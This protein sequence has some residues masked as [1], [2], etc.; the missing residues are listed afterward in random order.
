MTTDY[1][2]LLARHDYAIIDRAALA[3]ESEMDG[4]P[5]EPLVPKI[6]QGDADKMPGLVPLEPGA[7]H[8]EMLVYHLECVEQGL[9][10]CLLSCLLAAPDTTPERLGAH[11]T[12]RLI[13][14]S[15]R[16][17]IDL[18][19]YYDP[20]VFQNLERILTPKQLRALYGPVTE[21]TFRFQ[22]EWI[23][24][25]APEVTGVMPQLWAVRANQHEQLNR[26]ILLN[27]V[28]ARRKNSLDRPW[29]DLG[30]YQSAAQTADEA[31]EA[32]QNRYRL[33]KADSIT[34]ARH[35]LEHG[36]HFHRHPR[37]QTLLR[38]ARQC[39]EMPYV[40]SSGMLDARTWAVIEAESF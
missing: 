15:P 1:E 18:L 19:R 26:I 38:V 11:L 27:D 21:W 29:H 25:P 4:L 22:E 14:H 20:R 12:N 5:V 2:T 7:A 24:L 30:E 32:A 9:G 28:L 35:A 36:K 37:I 16:D 39:K 33:S 6:M 23:S 10:P 13:L 3:D 8:M 17:G 40:A 34:F 31:L